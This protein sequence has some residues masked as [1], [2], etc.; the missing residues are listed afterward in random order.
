MIQ[1]DAMTTQDNKDNKKRRI[2]PALHA[3]L[4]AA[5]KK[6]AETLTKEQRSLGGRRA[7]EARLAKAIREEKEQAARQGGTAVPVKPT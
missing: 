5:G 7:W 4:V 2:P 3:Q 6:R 1:S